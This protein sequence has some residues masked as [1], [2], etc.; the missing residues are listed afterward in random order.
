LLFLVIVLV[1]G[2]YSFLVAHLRNQLLFTYVNLLLLI[3]N[4]LGLVVLWF[5]LGTWGV[6]A[7]IGAF[8]VT[9]AVASLVWSWKLD[10]LRPP[11]EHFGMELR[12]LL[13][14]GLPLTLSGFLF[15]AVRLI[16]RWFIGQ[17]IGVAALG[18]YGTANI[19]AGAIL[20]A[21]SSTSRVALQWVARSEGAGL[22]RE[23]Q[24]QKIVLLPALAVAA[25]GAL[26]ADVLWSLANLFLP[27]WS[28]TQLPALGFLRIVL[29]AALGLSMVVF[30]MSVLRGQNRVREI[31][32]LTLATLLAH[33]GILSFLWV[34][35]AGIYWFAFSEAASFAF[36]LVAL[37]IRTLPKGA[38]LRAWALISLLFFLGTTIAGLEGIQGI[39]LRF[40]A[41]RLV[42]MAIELCGSIACTAIGILGAWGLMR[43]R[44][45]NLLRDTMVRAGSSADNPQ[46]PG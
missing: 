43:G 21:G 42:R 45:D 19:F 22:P 30:L 32:G 8:G 10:V 27:S 16:G 17:S 3:T 2:Y 25:T 13:A 46:V 31:Y 9:Q 20:L 11:R 37:L 12:S 29:Y 41:P 33:C 26:S 34:R 40:E 15:D 1:Q 7:A 28:P 23:E 6:L 39:G 44:T 24:A 18:F 36:L 35:K 38:G 4:G 14:I 5:T